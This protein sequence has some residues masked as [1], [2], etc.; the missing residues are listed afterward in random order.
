[1]GTGCESSKV[2]EQVRCENKAMKAKNKNKKTTKTPTLNEKR[3]HNNKRR[4]ET[5]PFNANF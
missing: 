5:I 2:Q 3:E 4:K 1:M